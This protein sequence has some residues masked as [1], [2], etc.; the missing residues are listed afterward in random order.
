MDEA[1]ASY[2][3][4]LSNIN[5][6]ILLINHQILIN[7]YVYSFENVLESQ[8]PVLNRYYSRG[9]SFA[10]LERSWTAKHGSGSSSTA[11]GG[12]GGYGG[13]G[14]GRDGDGRGGP[15]SGGG[16]GGGSGPRGLFKSRVRSAMVVLVE[17]RH[18]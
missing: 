13:G 18:Y 14:G 3:N 11:S 1:N 17:S 7:I 2:L 15:G 8:V 10:R 9:G 16:G 5:H 4:Y 12:G 6:S